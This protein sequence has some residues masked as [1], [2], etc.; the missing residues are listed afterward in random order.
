MDSLFGDS[1]RLPPRDEASHA[2]LSAQEQREFERLHDPRRRE[3]WLAGRWLSKQLLQEATGVK[4]ASRFEILTRD[5]RQR[6]VR[7][8]MLLDS[9]ILD[10]TLSI[11]HSDRGLLVAIAPSNVWSVGVD[12]VV[13]VPSHESFSR[14]WFTPLEHRWL[15]DDPQSRARTLWAIKEAVYKAAHVGE[16]WDPRQIEVSPRSAGQFECSYRGRRLER[17]GIELREVDAHL[18]AVACLPRTSLDSAQR[19]AGNA[20][21]RLSP[22]RQMIENAPGGHA[23]AR[24]LGLTQIV[25]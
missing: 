23:A 8:R 22:W 18:A 20:S 6:G 7:P 25:G 11:A 9:H 1:Q 12:L 4:N 13:D 14:T 24:R 10:W 2:W 17:L 5:Q 19:L 16:A 21:S 3:Q 15:Q